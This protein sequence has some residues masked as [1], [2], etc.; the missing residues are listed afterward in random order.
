M[1]RIAYLCFALLTAT[2]ASAAAPGFLLGIGYSEDLSFL[3][4]NLSLLGQGQPTALATDNSG[5]P[6]ILLYTSDTSQLPQAH[7]LGAASAASSFILKQT[8]DG[9]TIDY[10]AV[11]GFQ[12]SALAVDSA[13]SAYVAGPDFVAKLNPAGSAFLYKFEIGAGLDLASLA[14]DQTGRIY[15]AGYTITGTI[16]PTPG[17]F[18]QTIPNTVNQHTF[19]IR[20][21]AAGTAIDYATYLA[22]SS[23]DTAWGIAVDPSGSAVVAGITL[24]TDFPT[25]PGAYS[26]TV[27]SPNGVG[28]LTRFTPDGSGLVYST[29]LGEPGSI[30][31]PA[32]DSHGNATVGTN[33]EFLQRF[34]VA[35]VLTFSTTVPFIASVAADSAG[36]IYVSGN[37]GSAGHPVKNSVSTCQPSYAGVPGFLTVFDPSGDLLQSTYLPPGEPVG[38]GLAIGPGSVFVLGS[39]ANPPLTG[40]SLTQLLPDPTAQPVQLACVGNAA[41][42][43]P[44]PIEAGELVSLF[45]EGLGPKQGTQPQV[46][47]KSGVPS[48]VANV[49][50][51]FNGTASP[52]LY[53]QD[54]QIN[55]IVPWSLAGASTAEICVFY[56]GAETNCVGQ[57]VAATAAGVFTTDGYHAAALNQDG[58]IN[59][60]ANP[61]QRG[62][63]VS[64]FATGLG[65]ITPPQSDGS[66]VLPPLPTNTIPT[67][68]YGEPA[69]LPPFLPIAPNYV[70]LPVQYA[71]P[72]PYR[73]AGISQINFSL[74]NTVNL[75]GGF[76]VGSS[77]F[78]IYVASQSP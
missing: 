42:V 43:E 12:A 70:P 3:G 19:V 67:Q 11:L 69:D 39:P 72:A 34:D 45:W 8:A 49:R 52:L 48:Q 20:L 14:V 55:A 35:G 17:A 56:N 22:G 62:S 18:Q 21:N 15:V 28:F 6:Y 26:T 13:G 1:L 51:T 37:A 7:T 61:A 30:A 24:S 77:V 68:V 46:S 66:I 23:Y 64:I 60:A 27:N 32:V 4:Q 31:G 33:S 25:T 40:F 74:I 54:S 29:L 38:N 76:K 2:A 75:T 50:V 71:G 9:K 63:I 5:S 73:V 58:T 41:S 57:T 36:N 59:S 10:L 44:G 53:V 47:L 65:P 16:Q 78:G